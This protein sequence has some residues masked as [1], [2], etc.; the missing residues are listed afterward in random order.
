M[1]KGLNFDNTIFNFS[2]HKVRKI[3][4]LIYLPTH[5]TFISRER[6]IDIK[7]TKMII[8]KHF[9][10]H[11]PKN[12]QFLDNFKYNEAWFHIQNTYKK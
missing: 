1:H 12:Q 7:I 8:H 11:P 3:D 2:H 10:T 9:R 6:V 5:Y 4:I